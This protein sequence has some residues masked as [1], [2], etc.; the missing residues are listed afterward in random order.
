MRNKALQ[1][2]EQYQ[3]LPP[4]SRVT[5]ALSGGADSAALLHFLCSLQKERQWTVLRT[6]TRQEMHICQPPAPGGGKR[7]GRGFCPESVRKLAGP[8]DRVPGR[9]GHRSE[10][11]RR[12]GGIVWPQGAVPPAFPSGGRWVGSHCPHFER[13]GGNH[14]DQSFTGYGIKR[15]LFHPAGTGESDSAADLLHPGG[16]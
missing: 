10:K 14:M 1:A 5:V 12:I 13:P 11:C 7:A 9:C 15:T 2:I 4:G 6:L 8:A 3:M 16:N